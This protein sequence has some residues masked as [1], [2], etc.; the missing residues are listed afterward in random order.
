MKTRKTIKADAENKKS[1]FLLIGL[2]ASLAMTLFFLE[3]KSYESGPGDL[4]TMS[5]DD[6]DEIAIITNRTPPPPPPP[7]PPA[8][9]EVIQI[10]ED[11]LEIEEVEFEST[12]TD[13]SEVIEIVEEVPEE[14]DEIFNFAVVENKPI[15]PGCENLATEDEKFMCF[16]QEIM[17]HIGK[18]FDFPELARQMGIQGKVYV[19]FVIEKNGKVS[20]VTIARGV[21]KLIDDEAIRVIK[22]LPKFTPAKQR[23]KPVRMQYTVPI[24]ARL[25]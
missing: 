21:D 19:N 20:N 5:Y 10:V 18:N 14:E 6:E 13:E 15:Y 8:P 22:L 9:P 1:L 16:N 23:G 17:K 2:T 4:G 11:D 24:N 3:L 12:E 25:Q 7:P